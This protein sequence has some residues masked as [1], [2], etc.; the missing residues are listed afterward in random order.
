MDTALNMCIYEGNG[1]KVQYQIEPAVAA[2]ILFLLA[3]VLLY[4]FINSEIFC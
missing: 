3:V 4:V 2:A 1:R